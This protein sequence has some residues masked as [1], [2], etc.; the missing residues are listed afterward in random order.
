MKGTVRYLK[1]LIL[2]HY[3]VL[4]F[5]AGRRRRPGS[6]RRS[7]TFIPGKQIPG[8]S[9]CFFSYP[10]Q[11]KSTVIVTVF[12]Q[13]C[14]PLLFPSSIWSF[15]FILCTHLTG[16]H[17]MILSIHYCFYENP[18]SLLLFPLSVMFMQRCLYR[19]RTVSIPDPH[20][21]I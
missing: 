9:R 18:I 6:P 7:G 14:Y 17:S 21:R 16:F 5:Q 11:G 13:A 10:K 2:L 19:I 15:S 20:Q 12:F 3:V 4:F 8:V 1:I